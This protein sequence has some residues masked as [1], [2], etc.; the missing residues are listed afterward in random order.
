MWDL[1]LMALI[2]APG[3]AF[4][5]ASLVL[6][7]ILAWARCRRARRREAWSRR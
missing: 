4:L 5:T 2:V 7:D 3:A 6:L 1:L